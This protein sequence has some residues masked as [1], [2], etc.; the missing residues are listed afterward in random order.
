[1]KTEEDEKE[2]TERA[3]DDNAPTADEMVDAR[4]LVEG[5]TIGRGVKLG[6]RN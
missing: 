5:L 2:M 1:M 6:M 4:C 3:V